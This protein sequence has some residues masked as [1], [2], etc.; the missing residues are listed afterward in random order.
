MLA[1][2][3]WPPTMLASAPAKLAEVPRVG[4]VHRPRRP[5]HTKKLLQRVNFGMRSKFGMQA[6]KRYGEGSELLVLLR[7]KKTAGKR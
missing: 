1:R 6:A 2:R 4:H 7:K 5:S 3:R